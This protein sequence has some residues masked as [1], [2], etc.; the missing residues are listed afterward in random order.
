MACTTTQRTEQVLEAMDW[1]F[2]G[3]ECRSVT[4]ANDTAGDQE[5]LYFTLNGI[6][7]NY[8]E[9]KFYVWLDAGTGTDPMVSG[10]TGIQ[11]V[12]TSGDTASAIAAL[13]KTAIEAAGDFNVTLTEGV[14]EIENKFLGEITDEDFSNAGSISLTVNSAGFGGKLGAIAQGGG[15]VSTEQSLEDIL[16]DQT[17]DIVLDRI[18]KGAS[19]SCDLTLV[20]MNSS[21]WASLIGEGYGAKEGDAVGYGTSKLYQ[22]SFDYAGML[23]G[24]P[25]RLPLSDRSADI[26]IWKTTPNMNSINYAGSEV[27]AAEF[28]FIALKD[29][30][31]PSTVDIF[32]RGDHSLL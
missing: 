16:S 9:E 1:Y 11:V 27:Q 13:A 10:A 25:I 14:A 23:V 21:R 7:E 24:H 31:K 2:G 19:V 28:S 32:A 20:E 17:G 30:T 3:R 4:F 6:N 22:S 8:E 29:S 5:D 18:M 26:V 12:Y 15:S